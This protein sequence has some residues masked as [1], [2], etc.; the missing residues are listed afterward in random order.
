MGYSSSI[1]LFYVIFPL[2]SELP[3]LPIQPTLRIGGINPLNAELNP[4]L[5]AFFG[6]HNILHVSGVRV[7]NVQT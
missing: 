3:S 5:L 2:F 4:H 7:N 1:L 6:A